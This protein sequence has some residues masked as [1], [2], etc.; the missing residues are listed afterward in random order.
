MKEGQSTGEE[1]RGGEKRRKK[2]R[3][4]CAQ[5]WRGED[6]RIWEVV[7]EEVNGDEARREEARG[8]ER[9]ERER[10]EEAKGG[11]KR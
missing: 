6:E 5:V 4:M 7:G 2:V 8:G 11:D 10:R 9:G 3:G 1:V